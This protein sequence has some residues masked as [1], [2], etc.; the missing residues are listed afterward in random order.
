MRFAFYSFS[1]LTLLVT[2]VS[3]QYFKRLGGC[4][5]LGCIFPP[6]Q[7]EFLPHTYFDIRLEV[8]APVNGSEASH[9]GVPD[10][11]FTFCVS[12]DGG[13]CEDISS[14]SGIFETGTR[15]NPPLEKWSFS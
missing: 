14:S 6:D 15:S 3:A 9:N 1:G 8:H 13:R 2:G 4:P 7:T 12:K 10:D 11:K 5:K